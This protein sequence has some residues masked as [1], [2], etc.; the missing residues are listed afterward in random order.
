[1]V[2]ATMS[3]ITLH[4]IEPA[5]FRIMLQFMY[6]DALP[7]DDQLGGPPVDM[8]HKLLAAADRYALDRLKLICAQKLCDDMSG[9]TVAAT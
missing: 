1:M 6:T 5:T 9:D 2:E 3:S 4:D 7:G 8:M